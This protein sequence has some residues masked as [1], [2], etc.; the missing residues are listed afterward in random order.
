MISAKPPNRQSA[1]S[2]KPP[3]GAKKK[4]NV[5]TAETQKNRIPKTIF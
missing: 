5:S 2:A 1:T 4:Q 3:I